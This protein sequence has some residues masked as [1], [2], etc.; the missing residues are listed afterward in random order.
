MSD[1]FMFHFFLF[2]LCSSL[3]ALYG[4]DKTMNALHGADSSERAA[5]LVIVNTLY[6]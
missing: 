1:I 2:S 5:R 6:F 3:R 4:T